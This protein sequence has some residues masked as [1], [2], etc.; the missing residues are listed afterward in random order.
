ML[1]LSRS[2][3][4]LSE[5]SSRWRVAGEWDH[6]LQLAETGPVRS[7]WRVRPMTDRILTA[8]SQ[9]EQLT[10]ALYSLEPVNPC[11]VAMAR[12]LIR[13][14]AGP[15]YD[16]GSE[17]SLADAIHESIAALDPPVRELARSRGT[18]STGWIPGGAD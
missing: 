6:L 14:G 7:R 16:P 1:K 10:A 15:V 18:S 3:H 11:G 13:D 12:R 5:L 4:R 17:R 2:F 9:I 8:R